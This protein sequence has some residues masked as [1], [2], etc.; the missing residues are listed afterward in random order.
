MTE[1]TQGRFADLGLDK[2][3]IAAADA[4]GFG[5]ATPLQ[6]LLIPKVLAGQDVLCPASRGMGKRAGYLLPLLSAEVKSYTNY[7]IILTYSD[8][9]AEQ[10]GAMLERL[11]KQR[12]LSCLVLGP[13]GNLG[14]HLR[15][16]LESANVIIGS[17][18]S[19]LEVI[20]D[21]EM[22]VADVQYLVLDGADKMVGGPLEEDLFELA[23]TM[24]PSH[25]TVILAERIDDDV[26]KFAGEM[27]QW[28]RFVRL[29]LPPEITESA[30]RGRGGS[31]PKRGPLQLR[32][33]K[34]DIGD[35]HRMKFIR[36]VVEQFD[37]PTLLIIC[38]S[39]R[40]VMKIRNRLRKMLGRVEELPGRMGQARR[41]DRLDEFVDDEVDAVIAADR[42][43]EGIDLCDIGTVIFWDVPREGRNY[44][45]RVGSLERANPDAVVIML[46]TDEDESLVS[47]VAERS[48]SEPETMTVEL[49]NDVPAK[50]EDSGGG[51]S[52]GRDSGR[53]RGQ[54]GGW[55]RQAKSRW[56]DDRDDQDDDDDDDDDDLIVD[57]DD[58]GIV[59]YDDDADTADADID[60]DDDEDMVDDDYDDDDDDVVDDNR[61][62]D[63]ASRT[64]VGDAGGQDRVSAVD[65]VVISKT[66]D[67]K[68]AGSISKPSTDEP[69]SDRPYR[70]P[71]M[72]GIPARY[73]T[74]VFATSAD[75]KAYAPDG[76]RK[77][78]GDKFITGRRSR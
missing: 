58:D 18:A 16:Q 75:I 3:A 23:R 53:G 17:A 56:E 29:E 49:D 64:I 8:S 25:Q 46:V 44:M 22:D 20:S 48:T 12:A 24:S 47:Y 34:I 11:N 72:K 57:V 37:E 51:R 40:T 62:D 27:V 55:D 71:T 14:G 63:A 42:A 54:D 21:Y 2:S 65:S 67:S 36:P 41:Q 60:N 76:V 28:E 77:T 19:V 6:K 5:S 15:S 45:R 7:S 59:R 31:R 78:I 73:S 68:P 61:H 33:L 10:V 69:A 13:G 4:A 43:L 1:D 30:G 26:E 32:Q 9:D 39:P 66:P 52:D 38:Q 35:E 70:K 50:E 74:P